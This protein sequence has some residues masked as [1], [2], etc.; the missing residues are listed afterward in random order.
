MNFIITAKEAVAYHFI[1][2]HWCYKQ[3]SLLPP[4]P[5]PP[6]DMVSPYKHYPLSAFSIECP[7]FPYFLASAELTVL[8]VISSAESFVINFPYLVNTE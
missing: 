5:P 8:V 3:D 6:L 4:P 7:Y 2:D 1:R